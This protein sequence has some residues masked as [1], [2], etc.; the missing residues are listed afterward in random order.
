MFELKNNFKEILA[1]L[2][3]QLSIWIKSTELEDLLLKVTSGN[4]EITWVVSIAVFIVTRLVFAKSNHFTVNFLKKYFSQD[5]NWIPVIIFLAIL[6]I[7]FVLI[8]KFI[9]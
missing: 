2:I 4:K 6:C 1:H 8:F 5:S 7:A 9:T 3:I